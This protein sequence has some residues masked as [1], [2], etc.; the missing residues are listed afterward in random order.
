MNIDYRINCL[1]K[2]GEALN[3]SDAMTDIIEGS[4]QKNNWF[5]PEFIQSSIHAIQRE[6]L[7][8]SKLHAFAAAYDIVERK[9]NLGLILAGNIPA[10]GFHDVLCGFLCGADMTIKLSSKDDVLMKYIILKIIEIDVQ[11]SVEINI[12]ER[13]GP[14]DKI[15]ATG[16][17][18]SNRYFEYYFKKYPNLLRSNKTSLAVLSGNESKAELTALMDDI[19][20]YFG[21]GCRNVSKILVPRD[22]VFDQ[23][24]EA[25]VKYEHFFNHQK[26]MNNCDYNRTLL[27]MNKTEFLCNDYL[28]I[29]EDNSI[30]SQIATLH[31]NYYDSMEDVNQLIEKDKEHIQCIVSSMQLEGALPLGTSQT[32]SLF[33]FADGEDTMRFILNN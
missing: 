29:K 18:N 14:I 8:E 1:V 24:F 17:A 7:N 19:F 21:M 15:I 32:P 5:T 23:I 33:D 16:S 26:Y 31:F 11:N 13:L 25:S 28:I 6:Y 9:Q 20:M 22:Y 2:L 12:V 30:F 4:Y 10:V 27:L 3:P